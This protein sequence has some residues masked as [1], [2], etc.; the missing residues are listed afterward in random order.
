MRLKHYISEGGGFGVTTQKDRTGH[1][2]AAMVD[3]DGDGADERGDSQDE[4]DVLDVRTDHV[5]DIEV[6]NALERRQEDN[7]PGPGQKVGHLAEG[8]QD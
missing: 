8:G 2:H 7:Q 6:A 4:G 5:A 3:A 1:I